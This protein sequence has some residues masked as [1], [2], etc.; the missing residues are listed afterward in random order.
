MARFHHQMPTAAA[1]SA[2][3]GA[4]AA[5]LADSG[6]KPPGPAQ[7]LL[8]ALRGHSSRLCLGT[9]KAP[10]TLLASP[11][12]TRVPPSPWTLPSTP[13]WVHSQCGRRAE[14]RRPLGSECRGSPPVLEPHRWE[15]G[16]CAATWAA[17]GVRC[18]GST[19][20]GSVFSVPAPGFLVGSG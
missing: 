8:A 9:L 11:S 10:H 13:P 6:L 5:G 14:Q 15:R 17:Q 2:P 1:P 7:N 12:R 18:P 20:G 16:W 4:S 19:G 3:P